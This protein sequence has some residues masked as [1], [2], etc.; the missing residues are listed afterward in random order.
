MPQQDHKDGEN[1][2][3]KSTTKKSLL[4]SSAAVSG[5]VGLTKLASGALASSIA[6]ASLMGVSVTGPFR[7]GVAAVLLSCFIGLF[8]FLR[9]QAA[10]RTSTTTVRR[11]VKEIEAKR[12]E[13][14]EQSPGHDFTEAGGCRVCGCSAQAAHYFGWWGC[15]KTKDRSKKSNKSS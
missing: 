9:Y 8:F 3:A 7:W 14:N 10:N 5:T 13:L 2:A 11:L 4:W 6:A 1:S 15:K 12:K